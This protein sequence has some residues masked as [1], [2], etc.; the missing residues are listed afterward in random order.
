MRGG[1]RRGGERREEREE[2]GREERRRGGERSFI[3][4]VDCNETHWLVLHAVISD[5]CLIC[6]H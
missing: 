5:W 4:E 2:G 6:A 1:E 3:V